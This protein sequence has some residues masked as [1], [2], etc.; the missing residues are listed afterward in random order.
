M[1]SYP[2]REIEQ[3]W[4]RYW[5]D[6]KTFKVT[7]DP[8]VPEDKRLYV[9]D[10]SPY[11]SGEGLHVGHPEGYT[12]TD[13]Y[14]RYKKMN[15]FNVLHP[16]GF[17][18]YGL[19]AEN[20]AIKTGTH[21]AETTHKNIERFREQIKSIGFCYD[22]DREISTC[23]ADYYKWTQWI[24]LQL[25]KKGLAYE[26]DAPINWCPKCAT[27]LANEE[28]RDGLC[29]RCDSPIERRRIRQWVLKITAFAERLLKDLDLVDW[30]E[31]IKLMQ[32]NWIGRSEGAEVDFSVEGTQEVL[33]VFTT[34]PDTL[35][36]A[37]YMVLAPEHPLVAKVT[38]AGYKKEVEAYVGETARKSDL[39]RTDLNK[40]K[41]GVFTG[42]HAV[43]PLNGKKTPIWISDYVL[44]SYGTGAIM[45]VP[46]HDERDFEFASKYGLPVVQVVSRDGSRYELKNAET[47]DGI[48]VNS[49]E[50]DGM[51]TADFKKAVI[52]R[53]E[54]KGQGKGTVNFKLRDWVFSRQRY[55]GEPIPLVHCAKCG[56]VPLDEKDLPLTLPEVKNYKP[57]GTG[58]SPLA[59]AAEWVQTKCPKCGGPGNRETNT[60]PQWAGS[61]W[62]YLRFTDPKN[63]TVFAGR[64]AVNYWAPVD[65]YI[66]GAEHA[67]LHLLYA[68][69]WHKVLFDLGVVN[70]PEPFMAL[71]NQGMILGEN[72]EKMSKSRGNVV[73][74]DDVIRE[75]GADTLRLYE[76]FLGPLEAEKPWKTQGIQGP[77]RFLDRAWRL[78]EKDISESAEVPEELEKLRHKTVKLTGERIEALEFNTAV[79]QLMILLNELVKYDKLNAGIVKDFIKLLHPFAPFITEEM[80]VRLGGTPS[81]LTAA[82]PAFDPAKTTDDTVNMVIQVNGKLRDMFP[83]PS[84]ITKEE[85]EKRALASEK[86]RQKIDGLTIVRVIVVPG[87]LVN[88]VVQ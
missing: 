58:E 40:D 64:D 41:S 13:I 20:Y 74:P 23:D 19:P 79:S 52:R 11:P 12:A 53:L 38:T 33:R 70:S 65:L 1:S 45:A 31:S 36:G 73:N 43:N 56:I 32:K 24:F 55:W 28:V 48:A 67:V 3:K 66:G 10:M 75:Y 34:R 46:G 87:K 57:T 61:C 86:V 6:H 26:S 37:T 50:F 42:A 17:D 18:S 8:S 54:E 59:S 68:R 27:G 9:L 69:F 62:Y 71:R 29:D 78:L 4:I 25:F 7:E 44:L 76:M 63:E 47:V 88:I 15:G 21:P 77:F 35:F 60:M 30:N 72:G 85:M 2:F 22:W 5:D 81:V 49:G 80:W 51:T 39:Q 16:M 84:G 14:S 83:V 82:W